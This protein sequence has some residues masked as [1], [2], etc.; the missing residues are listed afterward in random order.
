MKTFI[1]IRLIDGRQAIAL[2]TKIE[3]H[4][5][6]FANNALVRFEPGEYLEHAQ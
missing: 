2:V 3:R 1:L 4:V 5:F 6:L